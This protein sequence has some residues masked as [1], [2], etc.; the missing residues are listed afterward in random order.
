MLSSKYMYLCGYSHWKKGDMGV[1]L[2]LLFATISRFWS[3]PFLVCI[4]HLSSLLFNVFMPLTKQ[5][6]NEIRPTKKKPNKQT[7][8]QTK[9]AD[10]KSTVVFGWSNQTQS[11]PCVLTQPNIFINKIVWNTTIYIHRIFLWQTEKALTH[12]CDIKYKFNYICVFFFLRTNKQQFT[13]TT[14]TF[15]LVSVHQFQGILHSMAFCK[16]QHTH[17]H[18]SWTKEH[19][20]VS[21]WC[22]VNR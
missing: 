6:I 3:H 17:I 20:W 1:E 8:A 18:K 22:Y 11:I 7:K 14:R 9:T 4:I 16:S 12:Q 13:P 10:K 21:F 2:L 19:S 15:P 5:S